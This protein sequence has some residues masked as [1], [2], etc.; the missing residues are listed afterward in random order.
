[1]RRRIDSDHRA[2]PAARAAKAG[3]DACRSYGSNGKNRP[4]R[5]RDDADGCV[6]SMRHCKR[7]KRRRSAR[8]RSPAAAGDRSLKYG[9]A[10]T[11]FSARF[12]RGLPRCIRF[13][14]DH[15][16]NLREHTKGI[17]MSVRLPN[18][19]Q[20]LRLIHSDPGES[21]P[22]TSGLPSTA[23][24]AS[25]LGCHC[26]SASSAALTM[27]TCSTPTRRPSCTW[28]KPS[29]A[30]RS[31]SCRR[32]TSA[33]AAKAPGFVITPDGYALTNSHVVGG[34]E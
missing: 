6:E 20:L 10:V 9:Q 2:T 18:A 15:L 24:S 8:V 28:S 1:M 26:S 25:G 23:P 11:A 3:R 22:S 7:V 17:V 34:R 5:R 27:P 19:D 21:K 13:F 29:A 31:A 30:R 16:L 12:C 32:E 4:D 33:R 14:R